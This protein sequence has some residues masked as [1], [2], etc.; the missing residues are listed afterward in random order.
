MAGRAITGI[1]RYAERRSCV[2]FLPT[3]YQVWF[4]GKGTR[5]RNVLNLCFFKDLV[6]FLYGAQITHQHDGNIYECSQRHGGSTEITLVLSCLDTCMRRTVTTHLNGIDAC[7]CHE[8]A[9][10]EE[11]LYR[12][13]TWVF[14]GGINLHGDEEV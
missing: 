10:Y 11:V 9:R 5:E 2:A 6:D 4:S 1:T 7:I 8:L 14:I 13:P 3:L 12:Q